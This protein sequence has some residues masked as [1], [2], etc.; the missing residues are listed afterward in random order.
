MIPTK[1]W[2]TDRPKAS[3]STADIMQSHSSSPDTV[4]SSG[5][6]VAKQELTERDGASLALHERPSPP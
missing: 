3:L 5:R 1:I 2:P 4:Q 6:F